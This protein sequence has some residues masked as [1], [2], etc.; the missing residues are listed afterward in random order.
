[1]TAEQLQQFL[2]A[3]IPLARC[4]ALEVESL[5]AS[6]IRL[7]APL[8]PNRNDKGTGFGGSIASLMTLAGWSLLHQHLEPGQP[9]AALMI[10]KSELNYQAPVTGRMTVETT[11]DQASL[12]HFLATLQQR[13][14][15]R[16]ELEIDCHSDQRLCARMHGR[17]VALLQDTNP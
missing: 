1:M 9:P 12:Q 7:A 13:R 15:A 16:V 5:S 3:E 11:I 6:A 4:M 2:L 8:E 17:F 14:K 10:H